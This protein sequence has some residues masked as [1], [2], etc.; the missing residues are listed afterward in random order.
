MEE[1]LLPDI[2]Q[3][4]VMLRITLED[5]SKQR[6]AYLLFGGIFDKIF[7]V[8]GGYLSD[9]WTNSEVLRATCLAKSLASP[10]GVPRGWLYL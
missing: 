6:T 1:I 2:C 9:S 3:F 5:H 4:T 8:A 10:L 7:C